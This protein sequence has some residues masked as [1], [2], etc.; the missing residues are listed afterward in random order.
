ML[1]S[2]AMHSARLIAPILLSLTACASVDFK[3]TTETSGTFVSV[4]HSF[5]IFSID[6]PKEAL[7]IARENAVDSGL[8]HM[9]VDTVAVNPDWGWWNWALDIIS[10]RKATLRG[11]WGF[12]QDD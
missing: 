4:G 5:T 7:Q 11:T 2:P 6:I 3:R 12:S 1:D 8:A 10:V 9:Q